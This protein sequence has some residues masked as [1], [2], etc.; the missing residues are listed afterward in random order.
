M[1]YRRNSLA[2]LAALVACAFAA[3]PVEAATFTVTSTADLGDTNAG[4][5]I[6]DSNPDQAGAQCTL[7]AAV[8]ETNGLNDIAPSHTI[9]LP[10]GTY[11]IA[12]G[13]LVV[14][15]NLEVIGAGAQGTIVQRAANAA[16]SRVFEIEGSDVNIS[17]VTILDGIANATNNFFGG[18]IRAQDSNVTLSETSISGGSGSSGGGISNVRGSLSVLNSTITGNAADTGG[19]DGGAI[20]NQGDLNGTAT[21]LIQNSTINENTARLAGG[22]ISGG[23]TGNSVTVQN[24]TIAS[25]ESGDRGGGGG[26]LVGSGSAVFYN[27]IVALNSSGAANPATPNCSKDVAATITSLGNNIENGTSCGFASTG[28]KS[29]TDPRLGPLQFAG[30]PTPTRPLLAG[31]PAINAGNPSTCTPLD[32]RDVPRQGICDIGAFEFTAAAAPDT[33]I[34]SGPSQITTDRTPA[35][36]FSSTVPG[37]TFECSLDNGPFVPCTSPFVPPTLKAGTHS[38]RVRARTA[39]GA[40]A[41]PAELVFAIPAELKDLEPPKLAKTVNADPVSGTVLV[42]IPAGASSSGKGGARASQKGLKFIPLREAKQVPV[43]SFFNTRRGKVRL[44]SATSRSGRRQ[45]SDFDGALFQTLQSG[46]RSAKGVFEVR[47]KGGSFKNCTTKSKSKK[48]GISRRTKRKIRRLRG[49]GRGRFRTRG[50]YSSATV[51]GTVWTVTDR[52]DGTLTQV[53]RGRVAVRDFRKKKNK[54]VRAGK[55][56]LAKAPG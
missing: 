45:T 23:N 30:G 43:G 24:S 31:S 32:Q 10:A 15:W 26:I 13:A 49:S 46:K 11:N 18:N 17:R 29:N 41:T 8:E 25:N 44:Q 5:N 34:V 50:R 53:R 19:G 48:A 27:S 21:L 51:R 36:T 52:C 4:D 14:T 22:I 33:V 16:A 35:F 1:R 42:A 37:T 9:N 7:R 28:D 54:L 2:L 47:L 3:G 38:F 40:D 55:R 6:C 56:Y 12:N 20:H 39:A